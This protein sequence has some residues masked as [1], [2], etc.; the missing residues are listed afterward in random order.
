L[1]LPQAG[2]AVASFPMA[3]ALEDF[4]PFEALQ[5]IPFCARGAGGT[6]T[7]ML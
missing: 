2:D 3:S 1:V 6:Q 7:T 4:N 5:D